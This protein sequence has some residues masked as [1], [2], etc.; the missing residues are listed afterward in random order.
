MKIIK[1]KKTTKGRYKVLL[2]DDRTLLLYEDVILKHELLLKKELTE[3]EIFE[4]EKYNQECDV[5]Y[6]ALN[7]INSRFKSVLELR[8]YLEKKEYPSELIELAINKLLKQGYLNDRSFC[9]SYINN[10]IITT[11][12]GPYKIRRELRD[13]G[14]SD[15]I[16]EDEIVIFDN[17]LEI[18]KVTKLADRMFRTNKTRGGSVLR[19]KI[20]TD[21]TNM[22]YSTDII[23]KVLSDY[24]FTN[25]KDIVKKEYDKL[26]KRL[27]RK[28]SDKELEYKIKE[29]LYKKGLYYED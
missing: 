8:K 1:Y 23:Y 5:Y 6:V 27:S 11:S 3:D 21:L 14:V 13:K 17:E 26:Y 20:T 9:K 7:S 22:G 4:A 10:Q 12:K 15:D 29:G 16:I 2:D 19:K 18:E 24:D 28:Y 25:D